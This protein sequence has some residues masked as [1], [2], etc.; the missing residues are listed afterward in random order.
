MDIGTIHRIAE[1]YFCNRNP[2]RNHYGHY[3]SGRKP[4]RSTRIPHQPR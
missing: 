4:T 3:K 1:Y 2:N